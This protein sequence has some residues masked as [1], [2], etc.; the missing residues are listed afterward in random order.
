MR[1]FLPS[2]SEAYLTVHVRSIFTP[3]LR[4]PTSTYS[5][6]LSVRLH[7]LPPAF[8]LH[9]LQSV[10]FISITLDH[11]ST[12]NPL[13]PPS[14]LNMKAGAIIGIVAAACQFAEL[15]VKGA[16]K[17]VGLLKSLKDTPVKLTGT[18]WHCSGFKTRY[19]STA[20]PPS[21]SV[22]QDVVAPTP[23]A[24]LPGRHQ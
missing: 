9:Y 3:H 14:S 19:G 5:A 12:T 15:I 7:P 4:S 16:T 8:A 24:K 1:P 18:P 13:P 23:A 17:G 21:R 2:Q 20:E 11:R 22:P 6:V 10:P